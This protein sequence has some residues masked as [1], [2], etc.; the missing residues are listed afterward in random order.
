MTEQIL[1]LAAALGG[2]F[3]NAAIAGKEAIRDE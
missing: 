2:S 1:E 3:S